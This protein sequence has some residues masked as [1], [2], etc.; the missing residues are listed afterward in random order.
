MQIQEQFTKSILQQT[1]IEQET[2]QCCTQ[3]KETVLDFSQ[4]PVKV[5]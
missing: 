2:Q 4:G 1:W 5:S 3:A